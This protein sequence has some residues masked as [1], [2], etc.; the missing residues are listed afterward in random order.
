MCVIYTV[1]PVAVGFALLVS[2]IPPALS[3]SIS[4]TLARCHSSK[5]W[6]KPLI[7]R[8]MDMVNSIN[9]FMFLSLGTNALSRESCAAKVDANTVPNVG[10]SENIVKN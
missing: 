6:L 3:F 5:G 7:D 9:L 10:S 1:S 4:C 8:Q 2:C